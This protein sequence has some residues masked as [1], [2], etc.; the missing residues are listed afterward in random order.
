MTA[1]HRCLT[2]PI[3]RR[4]GSAGSAATSRA[5]L[6]DGVAPKT[7]RRLHDATAGNPLGML[8]L[9]ADVGDLVLAP[10]GAPLLVSARVSGSFLRR[11][12]FWTTPPGARWSW[13]Q[14]V[15][16]VTSR[17][18]SGP[19]PRLGIDLASLA[20]SRPPAWWRWVPGRSSSVIPSFVRRY[21]QSAPAAQRREM[22]RALA[23][24]L[25]DRDVDRRAWHLAAAAVGVDGFGL[26]GA[27]ASRRPRARSQ[28]L[29]D[30][31]G[32]V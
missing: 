22:H 9:A 10:D 14:P 26:G 29:R 32:G 16:A 11:V 12:H 21:T 20:E 28:R 1:S 4:C 7:V 18:S 3:C 25:P 30:C 24:A 17:C 5:L 31:L 27:R 19:P 6:L 15:T 8:E 2:A 23:A 13:P